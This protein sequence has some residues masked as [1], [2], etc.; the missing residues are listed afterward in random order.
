MQKI[1]DRQF[2]ALDWFLR[3]VL[4]IASGERGV[5]KIFIT[6]TTSLLQKLHLSCIGLLRAIQ[7]CTGNLRTPFANVTVTPWPVN[8]IL[9]E[10]NKKI[11]VWT[12]ILWA[13][14][15][16]LA[17]L[18]MHFVQAK[19]RLPRLCRGFSIDFL[20]EPEEDKRTHWR[21]GYF[22]TL[23]VG[24]YF[25]LSFTRVTPIEDFFPQIEQI[26]SAIT[27]ISNF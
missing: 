11:Q 8:I 27:G 3:I 15:Y 25:P 7:I 26:F 18:L 22:L 16:T 1:D 14:N 6:E 23:D 24:L 19:T 17:I 9:A 12:C 4:R 10:K 21:L 20:S 13:R 5:A 2:S